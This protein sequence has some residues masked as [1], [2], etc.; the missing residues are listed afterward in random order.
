M[1]PS[2]AYCGSCLEQLLVAAVYNG[3]QALMMLDG[4]EQPKFPDLM[5]GGL[6]LRKAMREVTGEQDDLF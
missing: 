3:N 2:L 5:R 6:M 1:L 4:T